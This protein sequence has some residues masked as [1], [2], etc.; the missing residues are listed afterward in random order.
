MAFSSTDATKSECAFTNFELL[1]SIVEGADCVDGGEVLAPVPSARIVL[2]KK[3]SS[4]GAGVV[5]IM[6]GAAGAAGQQDSRSRGQQEQQ[7]QQETEQQEQ[8]S[9]RAAGAAEAA[10]QNWYETAEGIAG[11][12]SSRS[13]RDRSWMSSCVT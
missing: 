4:I 6:T 8:Q 10:G 7:E 1:S 11:A 13:S 3:S 9:S 5:D 12:R 2:L